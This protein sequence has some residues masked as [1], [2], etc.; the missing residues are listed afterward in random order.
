ML[1]QY[2]NQNIN[3]A[4]YHEE[5]MALLRC[6]INIYILRHLKAM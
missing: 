1:G 6:D 3:G 4:T 5:T 2:F